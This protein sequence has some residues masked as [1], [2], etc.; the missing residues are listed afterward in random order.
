MR[1]MSQRIRGGWRVADA[2]VIVTAAGSG[3]EMFQSSIHYYVR[4]KVYIVSTQEIYKKTPMVRP[5][6]VFSGSTDV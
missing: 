4:I 1:I 3:I 2:F 6:A 5:P